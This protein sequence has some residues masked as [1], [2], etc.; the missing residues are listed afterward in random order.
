MEVY[1]KRKVPRG[2]EPGTRKIIRKREHLVNYLGKSWAGA[3]IKIDTA[4]R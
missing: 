2:E 1:E 4:G 3:G